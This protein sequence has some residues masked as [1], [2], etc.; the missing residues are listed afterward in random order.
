MNEEY[1]S[2]TLP[3][4]PERGSLLAAGITFAALGGGMS[5]LLPA[6]LLTGEMHPVECL[7]LLPVILACLAVA[8]PLILQSFSRIHLVPEGIAVTLAGRTLRRL[9]VE[10]IRYFFGVEWYYKERFRQL[11]VSTLSPEEIT[12]LREA[13]LKKSVFTRDEVK[14]RR[15]RPDWQREFRQE[16]LLRLARRSWLPRRNANILWLGL[17][18]DTVAL[19]R[20]MYPQVPWEYLVKR[21]EWEMHASVRDKDPAAFPRE[22]G[23]NPEGNSAVLWISLSILV[24][25]AGLLW[26]QGELGM[27]LFFVA[28]MT[29]LGLLVAWLIRGWSD[30]IRLSPEK[31]EITRRKKRIWSHTG[32]EIQFFAKADNP[33]ARTRGT[34]DSCLVISAETVAELALRQTDSEPAVY[35]AA[36]RRLPGWENR[37][38]ARYVGQMWRKSLRGDLPIQI[39]HWTPERE[40]TLRELYP[41]AIWLDI[42]GDTL[43]N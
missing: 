14:F 15:R 4:P 12:A 41:Q 6:S 31:I 2:I 21:E 7:L 18:P 29:M 32:E 40:K 39:I 22:P 5:V 28:G 35:A 24:L 26:R 19:L 16:Y 17:E 9:P 20:D 33:M 42:T 10:N 13:R 8:V 11:G 27:A 34:A 23:E 1:R 25:A 37:A 36:S 30:M 38:L 43:C 3:P